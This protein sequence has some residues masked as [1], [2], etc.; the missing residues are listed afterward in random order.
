M[1]THIFM[2]ELAEG[3]TDEQVQHFADGLDELVPQ[4]DMIRGY[5]HGRDLG[6]VDGTWDY[7]VVADFDSPEDYLAYASHPLHVE[8]GVNRSRPIIGRSARVQIGS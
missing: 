7:A 2:L 1:I 6:L 5:L 3:A 4:L 8:L